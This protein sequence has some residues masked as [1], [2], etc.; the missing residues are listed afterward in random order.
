MKHYKTLCPC[1]SGKNYED[2]CKAFH[3]GAQPENALLLMRSRF[4][5]FAMNL[6][7]YI[8]ETTHPGSPQYSENRFL[9]K[10]RI[11][12][13]AYGT[14]FNRLEILD[15]KEAELTAEVV[16]TAWITQEGHDATFTEKSYFEKIKNRWLYRGGQ[17]AQGHIP[18]LVTAGQLKLLPLAYYGDP[19][20]KK[21]AEKIEEITEDTLKL[22]DE[23]IETMEAC[24]G[25]G[26]AA[27]Q[28]HHAIRLFIIRIPL[29]T[30]EGKVQLGDVKVLINPELSSF[31]EEMWSAPEGCLSIPI[32]RAQVE[33]SKEV[34]VE[35]TS[36]EGERIHEKV[37]GWHAK[38]IQHEYDHIEGILFTDRLKT[39][40][41]SKIV[42]FLE[43][44]EKR[45]H[46]DK[47]L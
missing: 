38:V 42:P 10:R 46:E 8:M 7:D 35:Y 21:K 15:F 12:R 27:P 36:M 19:V 33:R 28:V 3:E 45:M 13:L 41:F 31:S 25:M 18:N 44:L 26:L 20:L 17:L 30:E 14:V 2:C 4:S 32:L 9:W 47:E 11:S 37:S 6:P 1:S 23:M 16:F 39:E 5:A 34:V 22:I 24:N 40:E 29:E 43:E